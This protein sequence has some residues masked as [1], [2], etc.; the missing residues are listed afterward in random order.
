MK[1]KIKLDLQEIDHKNF[2]L[3]VQAKVNGVACR[4]LLDTG[5]SKTV[6]DVE[7]IKQ[8]VTDDEITLHESQSVGLGVTE[9]ET[10][11][12]TLKKVAFGAFKI[13]KI[14]V[15]V[16]P[17]GHVNTS[18]AKIGLAPIDG[19]LGS[20]ILKKYKA[21]IDFEKVSLTLKKK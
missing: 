10:H 6:F 11:V 5:A 19:V 18:Y 4:L 7:R 20:D 12:T 17:I 15:A 16:L 21:V 2:H 3:F 14:G 13:K 9:M 8:F 1:H